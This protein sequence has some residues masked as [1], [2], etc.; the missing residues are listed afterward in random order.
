MEIFK[1]LTLH[2]MTYSDLSLPAA[3]SVEGEF[4]GSIYAL[5][6]LCKSNGDPHY[7]PPPGGPVG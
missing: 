1:A 2:Q 7:P 6:I 5:I 4:M 3:T